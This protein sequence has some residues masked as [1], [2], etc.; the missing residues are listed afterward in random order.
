MSAQDIRVATA[1]DTGPSVIS[2]PRTRRQSIRAVQEKVRK[3]NSAAQIG[4]S[5]RLF[6]LLVTLMICLGWLVREAEYYTPEEGIGYWF[7]IVGGSMMLALIL[8]PLRKKL[9]AMRSWGS[10]RLWFKAH[11]VL[12]VLGPVFIL[13]HSNFQLGAVNSNVAFFAMLLVMGSGIIGRFIFVKINYTL[14]GAQVTLQELQRLTGISRGEMEQTAYITPE[15]KEYLQDFEAR[16]LNPTRN[17]FCAIYRLLTL[18]RRAAWI[19]FRTMGILRTTLSQQAKDEG[20][21][22]Q[23]LQSRLDEDKE[24]IHAYLNGIR[25]SAEFSSYQKIFAWWHIL[26]IPLFL[27]LVVTGIVHVLAVHL[28]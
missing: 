9:H 20:W 18:G 14:H 1:V 26:H 15:L 21:F 24:L 6:G 23:L 28:Y 27:M 8:Y 12:G 3:S 2:L 13:F 25:R 17:P 11:M 5:T 10:V 7:G 19:Q 16:E 4:I 22:P